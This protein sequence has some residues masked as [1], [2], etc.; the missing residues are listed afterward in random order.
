[1]HLHS[2]IWTSL[3]QCS[4]YPGIHGTSHTVSSLAPAAVSGTGAASEP[5]PQAAI[6]V[7][8]ETGFLEGRLGKP[9]RSRSKLAASIT[10]PATSTTTASETSTSTNPATS[11]SATSAPIS[12]RAPVASPPISYLYPEDDADEAVTEPAARLPSVS[13][14]LQA[15][16]GEE[17]RE[18]LRRW[19]ETMVARHGVDGFAQIKEGGC[20]SSLCDAW[21]Y[22]F[23]V[24]LLFFEQFWI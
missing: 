1:M 16:M 18:A 24:E 14:V 19:E 5:S 7:V 3:F 4:G 13:R 23:C 11:T 12:A 8:S 6:T 21:C 15:T 17:S 22:M 20:S 9:V 10:A 2:I